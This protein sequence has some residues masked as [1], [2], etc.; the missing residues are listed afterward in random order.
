MS[1]NDKY[2]GSGVQIESARNVSFTVNNQII[3]SAAN[4]KGDTAP[5]RRPIQRIK[6]CCE[7]LDSDG[8]AQCDVFK[9]KLQ[10]LY[11]TLALPKVAWVKDGR[12]LSIAKHFIELK[13]NNESEESI[14]IEDI[15]KSEN[16]MKPIKILIEG[17]PG[18]G[19][20]T[21]A[22][23]LAYDWAMNQPYIKFKFAFFIPLRELQQRSI[24]DAIIEIANHIGSKDDTDA[25]Q[26]VDN[27]AKDTLFIFDGLDEVSLAKQKTI[28]EFLQKE[29]YSDATALLFCRA[30]LFELRNEEQLFGITHTRNFCDKRISI[31]GITSVESKQQFLS[32]FF[33]QAI[34]ENIIENISSVLELFDSPLFLMMIPVIIETNKIIGEFTNKTEFYKIIFNCLLKHSY[35]KRGE[36]IDT[37]FDLFCYDETANPIQTTMS[38]F[39]KLAAQKIIDNELKFDGDKL[40]REIYELGFLIN[41]QNITFFKESTNHYEA[42]HLSTLEFAAAFAIWID[43]KA[44]K[45]KFIKKI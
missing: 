18:F 25:I 6:F 23:K 28:M 29:M 2:E 42:L 13:L 9:K 26:I 35:R 33:P 20:T 32:T 37:N 3:K 31:L 15:F 30:G 21:L 17:Q 36:D 10:R 34:A 39:G 8:N 5:V 7:D 44:Q 45:F 38:E 24:R 12:D 11:S 41:H 1:T 16:D 14:E 19:K 4:E 40:T 22:A 27:H 43:F